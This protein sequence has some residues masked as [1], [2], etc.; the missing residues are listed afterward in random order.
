MSLTYKNLDNATRL[1][2]SAEVQADSAA[3]TLYISPRLN[4]EGVSLWPSLLG[5]AVATKDDAWL[6]EEIRSRGLLKSHE[7]RRKPTGGTTLAKVP[8]NAHETLAEGE[9]NRFY[10]RGL[11]LRAMQEKISQVI[12]YR[13]RHSDNPRAESEALIGKA[14]SPDVLLA[15]LRSSVG[16]EP[17]LGV[18]PGPNSGL[19]IQLQ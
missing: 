5:E 4:D 8:V 6:A 14:F 19:S 15:D 18:P 13:A 10:A 7:E 3:G 16:V 12:A 1:Q 2:M 9:F 11:C 17:A